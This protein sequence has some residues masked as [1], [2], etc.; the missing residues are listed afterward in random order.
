MLRENVIKVNRSYQR[1]SEIAMSFEWDTFKPVSFKRRSFE[2]YSYLIYLF[3]YFLQLAELITAAFR[4]SCQSFKTIF[5]FK[6]AE[7]QPKVQVEQRRGRRNTS[8]AW[9]STKTLQFSFS[10]LEEFKA[11]MLVYF[12]TRE[13]LFNE[14]E[15]NFTLA[16]LPE[17][18]YFDDIPGDSPSGLS[19]TRSPRD[20]ASLEDKYERILMFQPNHFDI[21]TEPPKTLKFPPRRFLYVLNFLYQK[22]EHYSYNLNEE[23][24]TR[25]SKTVDKF[26]TLLFLKRE[27]FRFASMQKLGI[28]YKQELIRVQEKC[29]PAAPRYQE[30]IAKINGKLGGTPLRNYTDLVK[31]ILFK[32]RSDNKALSEIV[33]LLPVQKQSA[34][35]LPIASD[36]YHVQLSFI[37]NVNT[38]DYR[39]VSLMEVTLQAPKTTGGL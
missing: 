2:N 3:S 30:L 16:I 11:K 5:T 36:F 9:E 38:Q 34:R 33:P 21:P 23:T 1:F 18:L 25:L 39:L 13:N 37:N 29:K 22:I 26:N 7:K 31:F 20:G 17:E 28:P 32:C 19:H 8:K 27:F 12:E 35:E 14:S 15:M 10:R 4:K 24:F 6:T